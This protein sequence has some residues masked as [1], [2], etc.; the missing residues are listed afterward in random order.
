MNK[1]SV[2]YRDAGNCEILS[3]DVEAAN[4]SDAIKRAAILKVKVVSK[5]GFNTNRTIKIYT[6][7][8]VREVIVK[9]LES[10]V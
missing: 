5:Q 1:Y 6:V 2:V 7:E 3:A 8:E 9:L 4:F 10:N